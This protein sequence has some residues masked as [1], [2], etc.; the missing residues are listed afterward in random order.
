MAVSDRLSLL[1][2]LF[3]DVAV[4]LPLLTLALVGGLLALATQRRE[5]S[6]SATSPT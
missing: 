3:V 2:L 5:L 4:S 6:N 1:G